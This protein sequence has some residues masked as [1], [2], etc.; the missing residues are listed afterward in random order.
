[1]AESE[2][3]PQALE[4]SDKSVPAGTS[5]FQTVSFSLRGYGPGS[6]P[7][8]LDAHAVGQS[9]RDFS[10]LDGDLESSARDQGLKSMAEV[11][12]CPQA[13]AFRR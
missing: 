11:E 4:S 13:L 6:C 5:R 1:M 10:V 8:A 12:K 9:L 7:Q 3:C 2:K